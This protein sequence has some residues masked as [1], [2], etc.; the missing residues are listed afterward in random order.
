MSKDANK[1][2]EL[3]DYVSGKMT[4]EEAYV[5]ETEHAQDPFWQD[6]VEGLQAF[7]DKEKLPGISA[8]LKAQLLRETSR[9]K[10]QRPKMGDQQMLIV[11]TVIILAL[12]IISWL[13]FHYLDK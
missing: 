8:G 6:A 12:A 4:P 1:E 9:R 10:R 13:F 7:E 5:S 2:K 11:V 3:W